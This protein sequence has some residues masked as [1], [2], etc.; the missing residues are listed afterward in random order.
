MLEPRTV[1][2]STQRPAASPT[3]SARR[4]CDGRAHRQSKTQRVAGAPNS[5]SRSMMAKAGDRGS[6]LHDEV[7]TEE[8]GAQVGGHLAVLGEVP[9]DPAL[10]ARIVGRDERGDAFDRQAL[11]GVVDGEHGVRVAAQVD[12]FA[13]AGAAREGEAMLVVVPDAPHRQGVQPCGRGSRDDPVVAVAG[14]PF[15]RP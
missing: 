2:S 15:G 5:S 7:A 9:L 1:A 12:R 10:L 13:G 11:D 8:L 3:C 14:E 4:A 6:D